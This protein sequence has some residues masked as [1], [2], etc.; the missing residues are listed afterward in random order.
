MGGVST[1]CLIDSGSACSGIHAD[2][3]SQL[4]AEG[5]LDSEL[6]SAEAGAF[7][8]NVNREEY[9][10]H[11]SLEVEVIPYRFTANL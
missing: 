6:L 1:N 11:I 5:L 2:I 3:V 4:A 7:G 10:G 8:V 9:S